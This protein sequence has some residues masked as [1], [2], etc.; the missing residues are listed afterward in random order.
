MFNLTILNQF[1]D[2]CIWKKDVNFQFVDM[3]ETAAQVFG[4]CDRRNALG[5]TDYDIPSKLANYAAIFRENDHKV[6][7]N[8][9]LM[10]FL[11]IQPCANDEW[12]I[13]HVVKKPYY[14]NG[15]IAGVIGYSVD[16]TKTYIKLE[17]FFVDQHH[18]EGK[19][20]PKSSIFETVNI[21]KLSFRE[22][23][24]LFFLLRKCTAKE[25]ANILKLS[26]RTVEDYIEELKLKF[27]CESKIELI[28][29]AKNLGYFNI[30]PPSIMQKQLSIIVE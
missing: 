13:L 1:P 8:A 16:I 22:H 18:L 26:H 14:E 20:K 21:P 17:Q 30:I 3:N 4:F 29:K 6:I 28:N 9:R 11:E 2:L 5:K 19:N 25:I 10:K 12:K 15:L 7:K 23:E 24:C 27:F